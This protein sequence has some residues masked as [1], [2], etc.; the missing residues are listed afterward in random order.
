MILGAWGLVRPW[1]KLINQCLKLF[2][3]NIR[4]GFGDVLKVPLSEKKK[5]ACLALF[6][7]CG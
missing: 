3:D 6:V 4:I 2:L 5:T 7:L 1:Y